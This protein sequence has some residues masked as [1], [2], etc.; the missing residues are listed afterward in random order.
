MTRKAPKRRDAY[1]KALAQPVFRAR[2]VPDKRRKLQERAARRE[3][4]NG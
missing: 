3:E 1:A 2:R 4:A